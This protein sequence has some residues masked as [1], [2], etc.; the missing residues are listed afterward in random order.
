MKG[1]DTAAPE[2]CI[3]LHV[4]TVELKRKF[5]LS[6][7]KGGQSTVGNVSRS[8]ESIRQASRALSYVSFLETF[9]SNRH[10]VIYTNTASNRYIYRGLPR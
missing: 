4:L 8:I 2:Q 7:Q 9:Y 6:L 1:V 5:R 10:Q 3:K